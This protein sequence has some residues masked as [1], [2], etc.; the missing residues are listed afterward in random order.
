MIEGRCEL[1]VTAGIHQRI[2]EHL[3]PGDRDEH[4]AI[5]RAGTVRNGSSLRLLVQ[6]VQR[7]SSV[8]TTCRGDTATGR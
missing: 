2:M 3:F 6:H 4:G 7:Q 5:L 8:L 1:L